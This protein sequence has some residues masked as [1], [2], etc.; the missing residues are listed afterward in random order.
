[1]DRNLE[2][3]EV[4]ELHCNVSLALAQW[5]LIEHNIYILFNAIADVPKLQSRAIF[6]TIVDFR[7]RLSVIDSLY[8]LEEADDQEKAMWLK[9]S[10]RI[11]KYYSKRHELAHG[12]PSIRGEP[13]RWMPMPSPHTLAAN[14]H[15][16]LSAQEISDRC[17]RF[18]EIFEAVAWFT[19]RADLRRREVAINRPQQSE[20]PLLIPRLRELAIRSLEDRR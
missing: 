18:V 20:E 12:S 14:E 3:V 11:R 9:M 17:D 10:A 8:A 4:M 2:H 5:A 16:G 15:H 19:E 6:S 13:L 1:M 7:T